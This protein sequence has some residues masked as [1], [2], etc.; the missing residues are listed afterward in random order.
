MITGIY[1]ILN[2]INNKVYI[3]SAVNIRK[4]WRDH[5][6]HL[7]HNIHH[8]SHLQSAWNKYSINNF[9]FSII[10]ECTIEELL[11]KEKE[12][13][14]KFNS[15]DNVYGYNVNDPEHSFL[16]KKHS[17]KT[18]K[19]LSL[20][21]QGANNP[22]FG[23]HGIEHPMFEKPVSVKTRNK[24]SLGRKGITVGENHPAAKL[25]S[26]D[27]IKIREMYFIEGISQKDISKIFNVAHS[28]INSIILRNTW[29]HVI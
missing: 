29:A 18:K 21:K 11:I 12:F 17:E 15:H 10:I 9:E 14:L 20:Q 2:K 4:R 23:K 26:E 22:M 25:K 7:I 8:N 13:M 1:K 24:I 16:N 5:K 6:W 19:I 27:I 28:N 3:G